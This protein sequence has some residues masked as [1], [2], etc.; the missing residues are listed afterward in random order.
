MN[1][2]DFESA[3]CQDIGDKKKF[4][5][6]RCGCKLYLTNG[7][8]VE[9]FPTLWHDGSAILPSYCPNCGKEVWY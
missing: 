2:K 7:D 1:D 3:F 5:C 4:V 6:S 9:P 8:L